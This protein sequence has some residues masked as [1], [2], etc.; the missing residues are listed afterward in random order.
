MNKYREDAEDDDGCE[1][2][3]I[4]FNKRLKVTYILSIRFI[5]LL[6]IMYVCLLTCKISTFGPTFDYGASLEAPKTY[7]AL[8]Q[9]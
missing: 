1:N 5:C 4:N 9:L 8:I 6:P 2:Y 3:S 7:S